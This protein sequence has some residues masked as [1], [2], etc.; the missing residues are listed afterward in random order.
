MFLVSLV[1]YYDSDLENIVSRSNISNVNPLAVDVVTIW[2][3]AA[4]CDALVSK[5]GTLITLG[6]TC[7]DIVKGTISMNGLNKNIDGSYYLH[8]IPT[9]LHPPVS[10]LSSFGSV[11]SYLPDNLSPR[12]RNW[13]CDLQPLW[14][15]WHSAGH[16]G[17]RCPCCGSGFRAV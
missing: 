2:I 13:P 1:L 4:H 5:V 7:K 6:N 16:S 14:C 17:W 12:D 3:P 9:K 15:H 8:L 10:V 11:C